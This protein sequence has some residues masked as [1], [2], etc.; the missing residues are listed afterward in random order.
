MLDNWLSPLGFEETKWIKDLSKDQFGRNIAIH[1]QELPNLKKINLVIIGVSQA[2]A[3][4]VRKA[5][6]ILDYP[7]NAARIADLG[8]IRNEDP[9]FII[10]VIKELLQSN[11][12]PILIGR[13]NSS[14]YAQFQA[15]NSL[16]RATNLLYVDERINYSHSH[17]SNDQYYLNTILNSRNS[18]LFNLGIIGFQSHFTSD[19]LLKMLDENNF[20]YVRL[21]KVKGAME[22]VEPLIRDA[23]IICFN[24]NALKQAEAPGVAHPTPS[25]LLSEEACKISRYAGI[26]DKLTSMGFYGYHHEKDQFQQTAQVIAQMIWYFL[27]GFYHRM[28]DFPASM[29]GLVEY[30]VEIKH[31]DLPI[32]FWKSTKS[33]RWWM[34]VPVDIHQ[35]HQRHRL[36]PCSYNDYQAASKG[37]L[38]DRLLNA[39]K[40]FRTDKVE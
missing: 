3:D 40:R 9:S 15:Y 22:E 20:D 29:N 8:N 17:P 32:T 28:Q 18:N 33:G 2:D 25:G 38:P 6:Y 12:F 23:D 7:F 1:L 16:K 34:Q 35:K 26:S 21:G 11:I 37:D 27:D 19:T 14:S 24:A 31:I 30:I 5:L 39:F 13:N 10:P 36:V 4:E